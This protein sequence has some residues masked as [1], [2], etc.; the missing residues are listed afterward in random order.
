VSYPTFPPKKWSKYTLSETC[1]FLDSSRKPV[2]EAARRER[3]NEKN[4]TKL[5]PYYGANGQAGWIDDYIFNEELILLAEDG[6][7]FG[8]TIRPI[9]YKIAGKT[10]VN[11]H[12]HVLRPKKDFDIDFIYY[13]L[14]LRPD[15]KDLVAGNTRDKLNQ[16]TA[17]GILIFAPP[18]P[19]QKRIANTIE[20]KLK[21]LEKVKQAAEEQFKAAESLQGAYLREVFEFDDLPEG[22]EWVRLEEIAT[23]IAGQSPKSITYNNEK[24]GLPFYQGK[25]DFGS[26]SPIPKTWCNAPIRIA[27]QGDI[28]LSVRAPV[29]PTNMAN[30]ECCIG[31]G[32][33]AIRANT[34]VDRRCL[35]T[36]FKLFEAKISKMGSGSIFQAITAKDIKNLTI[37]LPPLD[38]QKRIANIIETKFNSLEKTKQLF[39]QQL[40]YINALPGAILRKAFNG[41]L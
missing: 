36:Y 39:N 41:E 31:R 40:S 25:A 27:K 16:K 38:E 26:I 33:Y 12:A 22:W 8:S 14:M 21:A 23:I 5:Y 7:F 32:L 3:T 10:W 19:E 29:G 24:D 4:K 35:I 34:N 1:C 20:T 37:P 28:L 17:S 11:N 2:N 6:G 18:L 30:E 15:I 9:A 13:S